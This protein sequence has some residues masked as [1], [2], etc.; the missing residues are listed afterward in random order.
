MKSMFQHIETYKTGMPYIS[1]HNSIQ[2]PYVTPNFNVLNTWIDV[3]IGK[4]I[5]KWL[6]GDAIEF[7]AFQSFDG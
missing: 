6:S 7:L 3:Q 5:G 4:N 1:Q 2:Y